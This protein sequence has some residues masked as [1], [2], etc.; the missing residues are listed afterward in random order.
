MVNRIPSSRKINQM[1]KNKEHQ[2]RLERQGSQQLLERATLLYEKYGTGDSENFNVFSVLRSESDEVNLHSRF[3][4]ALLHHRKSRD[5]P[6]RNLEDFLSS[7]AGINNF[8]LDGAEVKREWRNMDIL[9]LNTFSQQAMVIENKIRARDRPEQLARYARQLAND[10]FREP[11]LLYLTLDG[12]D[13]DESSAGGCEVECMSYKDIVP[14]LE[15]CQERAYEEPRLRESIAQY[16]HLVR[17]LTG[18]DLKGVYMKEL[19]K[20]ILEKDNL[21]LAHDLNEA[22]LEAKVSLL[23]KFW[24]EI[25]KALRKRIPD[26]PE[27]T[28]D[29]NV[30]PEDITDILRKSRNYYQGLYYDYDGIGRGASLAVEAHTYMYFGVR[31]SEREHKDEHKRLTNLMKGLDG[32]N[33]PSDGWWPWWRWAPGEL[34]LK[35]PTR[36]NLTQLANA[37]K[38][39]KCANEI[40]DGLSRVAEWIKKCTT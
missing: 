23:V 1:E 38:R 17:K 26:L 19:S 31:C 22:M 7:V 34:N 37:Q 2:G 40:A 21:L 25:D 28:K 10:G 30:S 3:L 24:K 33:S 29:S 4:A 15:R 39:K 36:E 12:R 27:T 9:I 8:C 20:L 35:F 11:S 16:V 14:W 13:P 6:L 18:T 32:N 5:A